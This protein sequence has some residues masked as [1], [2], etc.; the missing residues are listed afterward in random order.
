MSV[1]TEEERK[2]GHG[3][4]CRRSSR[5]TPRSHDAGEALNECLDCFSPAFADCLETGLMRSARKASAEKTWIAFGEC[6]LPSSGHPD[7]LAGDA[8]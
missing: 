5:S 6:V 7:V 8:S 1:R 3:W 2:N 4:G